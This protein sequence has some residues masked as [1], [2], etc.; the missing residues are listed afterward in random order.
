MPVQKYA[1][2]FI[3]RDE[4]T[5]IRWRKNDSKFADAVQKAHAVWFCKKSIGDI[6]LFRT[7]GER[8]LDGSKSL[9]QLV[10]RSEGIVTV[11]LDAEV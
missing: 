3:G 10:T 1:A 2:Q 8:V 11:V 6:A 4:D 7:Y 5:V 9:V